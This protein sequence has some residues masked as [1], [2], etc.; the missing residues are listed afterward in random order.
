MRPLLLKMRWRLNEP[1]QGSTFFTDV[2]T[3]NVLT[4]TNGVQ[5]H[6][7]YLRE[8]DKIK[9]HPSRKRSTFGEY[10]FM[11][12]EWLGVVAVGLEQG[13]SLLIVPRHRGLRK[14]AMVLAVHWITFE[15]PS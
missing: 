7:R 12:N 5:Y 10:R 13:F 3:G 8:V 15:W 14:D 6:S 4:T 11:Q 2:V 9:A 1:M